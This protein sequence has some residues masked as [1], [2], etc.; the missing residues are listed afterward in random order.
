MTLSH[1]DSG[2]MA[3]SALVASRKAAQ[4][5]NIF[6]IVHSNSEN[7]SPHPH[8]HI[9]KK[10]APKTCHEM[11]SIWHESPLKSIDFYRKIWHTDPKNGIRPPPLMLYEPILLG[12]R[13]V[14]NL[15]K[16]SHRAKTATSTTETGVTANPRES[17]KK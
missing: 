9:C 17:A 4:L 3:V 5:H 10:H 15:L 2:W 7:N 13:V 8:S 16:S 11:G 6:R 14:F 1:P 12:V